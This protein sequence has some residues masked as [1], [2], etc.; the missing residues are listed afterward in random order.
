MRGTGRYN[1]ALGY[2][3][4][5]SEH[6]PSKRQPKECA[7]NTAYDQ[8]GCRIARDQTARSAESRLGVHFRRAGAYNLVRLPKLMVELR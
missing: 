8:N 4:I 7:R 3:A 5:G 1:L 6:R 2:I